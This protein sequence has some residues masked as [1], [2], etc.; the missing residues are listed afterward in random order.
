MSRGT[1]RVFSLMAGL[2]ILG[3]SALVAACDGA[4]EPRIDA[5]LAVDMPASAALDE[6]LRITYTWTP[7]AEFEAPMDD[8]QVFVHVM[9]GQGNLVFQDD[10]YPT[11]PTSQWEADQP[12]SYERWTY[13]PSGIEVERLDFVVGLYSP[14]G[15]ALLRGDAG[16][17]TDA[18]EAHSLEVRLDDMSGVPAYIEGWQPA[19]GLEVG[20][21]EWRWTEGVAR[22]AFTNPRRASILHLTAHGPVEEVGE[23]VLVLRIGETEIGRFDITSSQ[24]FSERVEIPA[25]AMGEDDWV[26]LTLEISPVLVPR[27]LDP[28]AVDERILGLQV[29]R[30]YLSPS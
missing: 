16:T 22:A 19:E 18:V 28:D 20:E 26:E 21:R 27:D 10:H 11:E 2:F 17:W 23:Q 14:D 6:P 13:L 15:R 12:Q 8:Y 29:F 9:D 4:D 3:S 30:L 24:E 1:V 5:A 25:A 7:G